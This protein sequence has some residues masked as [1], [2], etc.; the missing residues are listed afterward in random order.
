ME[1]ALHPKADMP[2]RRSERPPRA[3]S[4]EEVGRKLEMKQSCPVKGI[5]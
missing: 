2:L 5:K 4:V 3:D 1:S